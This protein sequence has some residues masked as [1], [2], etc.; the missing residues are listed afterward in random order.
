MMPFAS[1]KYGSL[2]FEEAIKFFRQKVIMPVKHWAEFTGGQHARAFMVS[3]AMKEGLLSDLHASIDKAISKGTTLAEFRKDFDATVAANGWNYKGR[4][5][6]RTRVIFQT[7]LATSYAAGRYRQMSDPAVKKARPFKR[8]RALDGGN[9]RKLH[10]EWKNTILPAD[11]PWWQTHFAPCGWGCQCWEETVSH[12]EFNAVKNAPGFKTEAPNDGTY[13][14]KNPATGKT[15][16]IR[17]GIDPGWNYHPGI[18]AYGRQIESDVMDAWKAKGAE[19]WERLTPGDFVSAGRPADIPLDEPV[20]KPMPALR[21][22]PEMETALK[23]I[24]GGE[25]KTFLYPAKDFTHAMMVDAKTLSDRHVP[26]DRSQFLP[27]LPEVLASPFE[28]WQSFV[29]RKSTGKVE[30]RTRVIKGFSG[31][32]IKG[33]LAVFTAKNGVMESWSM[34]PSSSLGYLDKQRVGKLIYARE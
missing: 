33:M 6:W 4:R 34:M 15:E 17:K 23:E 5:G 21:T 20:A 31:G 8:W 28:V 22:F 14:W 11:H 27:W 29:R 12:E 26:L 30:L 18:A 13:D 7:N 19:A 25:Q 32:K 10:Q 16:T 1:A 2:P 3:G 9:R 24:L